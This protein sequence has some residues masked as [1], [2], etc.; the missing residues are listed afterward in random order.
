M[1]VDIV[2]Q[3]HNKQY[4]MHQMMTWDK[5][6]QAADALASAL[7]TASAQLHL[8]PDMLHAQAARRVTKVLQCLFACRSYVNETSY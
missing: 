1:D 4:E 7:M 2:I 8:N 3:Q 6:W 5:V